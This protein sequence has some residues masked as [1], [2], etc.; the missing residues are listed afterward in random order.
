MTD[1]GTQDVAAGAKVKLT[2]KA[3]DSAGAKLTYT[4]RNLAHG[5]SISPSGVISGTLPKTGRR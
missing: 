2:L 4:A 5:L 1:P 3:T